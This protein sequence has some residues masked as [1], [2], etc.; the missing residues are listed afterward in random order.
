MQ[1]IGGITRKLKWLS[2]VCIMDMKKYFTQICSV[3]RWAHITPRTTL[4]SAA[5]L[6][7][8]FPNLL[9]CCRPI[10]LHTFAETVSHMRP[11]SSPLDSISRKFREVIVCM[12]YFTF[13]SKQISF[14]WMRSRYFMMAW[15]QW[16]LK[17]ARYI[18]LTH[19]TYSRLN[20]CVCTKTEICIC[21]LSF[22]FIKLCIH[23]VC[24]YKSHKHCLRC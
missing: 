22:R 7:C 15:A 4:I 20:I 2:N 23:M 21:I 3:W 24:F 1:N 5:D 8:P 9:N 16:V 6:P 19:K 13:C 12:S 18:K 10:S 14:F 17:W 11:S